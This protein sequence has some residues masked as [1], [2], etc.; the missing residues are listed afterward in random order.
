MRTL[1]I[2]GLGVLS[3]AL[4]AEARTWTDSSGTH[5]LEAELVSLAD[6]KVHL[7]TP[8]GRM[9]SIPLSKLSSD[10]RKF[11]LRQDRNLQTADLQSMA[12]RAVPQTLTAARQLGS[13]GTSSAGPGSSA[14]GTPPPGGL[15][16]RQNPAPLPL[17]PLPPLGQLPSTQGAQ[18]SNQEAQPPA[19]G[20]EQQPATPSKDKRIFSGCKSTFQLHGRDGTGAYWKGGKHYLAKLTFFKTEGNYV[21]FTSTGEGG[22]EAWAFFDVE[23]CGPSRVYAWM[24]G[25]SGWR[26]FDYDNRELPN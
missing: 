24:S 5:R 7:Q 8:A 22:V 19:T 20:G 17:D 21:A 26:L 9:Y 23:S 4:V 11:V 10:D 12:D 18:S 3:W 2:A 1:L 14:S 13:S 25:S 6:G 16:M 15:Q